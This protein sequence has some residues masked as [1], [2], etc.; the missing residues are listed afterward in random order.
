MPQCFGGLGGQVVFIDT[1]G[2]FLVQRVVD[3]A[4]A[5]VQHCSLLIEDK[6][7]QDA[8]KTF[9]VETILSNIFLVGWQVVMVTGMPCCTWLRWLTGSYRANSKVTGL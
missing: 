1:E 7:Q 8:M 4:T 9:T 6:E 3:L 2:S 5:A